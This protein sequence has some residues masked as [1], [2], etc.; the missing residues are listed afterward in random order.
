MELTIT[1]AARA[2]GRSKQALSQAIHKGRLSAKK[3]ALGVWRVDT[4]ELARVYPPAGKVDANDGGKELSELRARVAALAALHDADREMIAEL[5][6]TRDAWKAQAERLALTA[7]ASATPPERPVAASEA[8]AR[9]DGQLED[10]SAGKRG[11]WRW[12]R[13]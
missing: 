8:V 10:G 13:G 7:G 2:V 12:L 1:E 3:D 9:P 6:Q 11:F 4:N 5:R